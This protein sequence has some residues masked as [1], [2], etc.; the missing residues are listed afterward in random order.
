MM[1]AWMAGPFLTPEDI[2]KSNIPE[3]ITVYS[4]LFELYFDKED[5][6]DAFYDYYV[7]Y[8]DSSM[9]YEEVDYLLSSFTKCA[10]CDQ[11]CSGDELVDTTQMIGGGIGN[12]CNYC[13]GEIE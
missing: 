4:E 7:Y 8:H 1:K 12:V 3:T 9:S 5:R 6:Y 13:I 10:M 2:G 11:W